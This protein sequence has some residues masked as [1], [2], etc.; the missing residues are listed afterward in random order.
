MSNSNW[1][2]VLP[3]VTNTPRRSINMSTCKT[4]QDVENLILDP[5]CIIWCRDG[6]YG[7]ITKDQVIN[8]ARCVRDVLKTSAGVGKDPRFLMEFMWNMAR[9][10]NAEAGSAVFSLV[11]A[12][13]MAQKKAEGS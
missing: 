11:D 7:L 8:K 13:K 5:C 9:E 10:I 12:L 1:S 3:Y 4:L 6:I 2:P